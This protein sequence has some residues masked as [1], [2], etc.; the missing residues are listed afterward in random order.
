MAGRILNLCHASELPDPVA[1]GN[2]TASKAETEMWCDLWSP[3]AAQPFSITKLKKHQLLILK[4]PLVIIL[5]EITEAL[6]SIQL[7]YK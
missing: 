1:W 5:N 2:Q 6:S 7:L 4:N 3:V